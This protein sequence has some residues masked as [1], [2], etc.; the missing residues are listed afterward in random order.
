MYFLWSCQELESTFKKGL[1]R[2]RRLKDIGVC[3]PGQNWQ[4][5]CLR[6][7]DHLW[8]LALKEDVFVIVRP[9]PECCCHT[10]PLAGRLLGQYGRLVLLV[11]VL[12]CLRFTLRDRPHSPKIMKLLMTFWPKF[13]GP[14]W[15]FGGCQLATVPCWLVTRHISLSAVYD[16]T[17]E[18]YSLH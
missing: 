7:R 1:K 2:P 17:G 13:N 11:F 12:A 4:E 18:C 15:A 14:P 3:R 16:Q 9:L 8:K 5:G 6:H 10:L